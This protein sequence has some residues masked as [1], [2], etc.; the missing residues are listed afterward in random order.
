M[1][2]QPDR[3]KRAKTDFCRWL[4]RQVRGTTALNNHLSSRSQSMKSISG[5]NYSIISSHPTFSNICLSTGH[6]CSLSRY[7]NHWSVCVAN[8]LLGANLYAQTSYLQD[9]LSSR[10]CIQCRMRWVSCAA[11]SSN[12]SRCCNTIVARIVAMK[13]NYIHRI[14]ALRHKLTL[15]ALST[16]L[17][18]LM[19]Q[20]SR[21][22]P[23]HWRT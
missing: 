1:S 13:T 21:T 17:A 7:F 18:A 11:H 2:L 12:R 8:S 4:K 9:Y 5:L 10:C 14:W 19:E 20:V 15:S 6:V 16:T 23:L 22:L 3:I